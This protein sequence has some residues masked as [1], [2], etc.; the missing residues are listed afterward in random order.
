MTNNREV[1]APKGTIIEDANGVPA[2]EFVEDVY[3]FEPVMSRSIVKLPERQHP[4]PDSPIDDV[5]NQWHI[6]KTGHSLTF[7]V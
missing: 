6:R 1:F 4:E 5:I 2:Y 3:R 7:R